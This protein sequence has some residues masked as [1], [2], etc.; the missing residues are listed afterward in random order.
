MF[1]RQ[2]RVIADSNMTPFL[3]INGGKPQGTILGPILF[4]VMLNGIQG[5]HSDRSI[6]VK[7]PDDLNLSVLVKGT[8]DQLPMKWKTYLVGP[9]TTL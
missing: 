7:F 3:S 6:L 8:Q 2:Q 1:S 4:S 9:R 5:I